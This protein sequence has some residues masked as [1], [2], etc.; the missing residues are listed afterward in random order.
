MRTLQSLW[1]VGLKGE[2]EGRSLALPRTGECLGLVQPWL[3]T[4]AHL[5]LE[6][7]V[8]GGH[9]DA[10]ADDFLPPMLDAW[11]EFWLPASALA[12]L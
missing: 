3:L 9:S 6:M 8:L 2:L 10:Q 7:Q 11:V 4:P 5:F 1:E 12:Q